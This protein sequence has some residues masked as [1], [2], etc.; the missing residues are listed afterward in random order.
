MAKTKFQYDS[1]AEEPW[2]PPKHRATRKERA[3]A[4]DA[5]LAMMDHLMSLRIPERKRL[6]LDEEL[7]R[8]FAVLD[9]IQPNHRSATKRQID[10]IR[11]MLRDRDLD[12]LT[13]VLGAKEAKVAAMADDLN[14][15]VAWRTRMVEE[16]DPAIQAFMEEHPSTDRQHLRSLVTRLRKLEA[17]T[18]AHRRANKAVMAALRKSAGV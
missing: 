5:A 12:A 7:V 4:N 1:T 18:D 16:G 15:L 2:V 11:A 6:D 13:E 14:A 17:G 9:G 3:A 8:E 10:R